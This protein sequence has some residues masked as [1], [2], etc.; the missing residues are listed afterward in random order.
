MRRS[1]WNNL[2]AEVRALI[3]GHTGQVTA[4]KPADAGEH[5]DITAT[6]WT[7]T[8]PVFI[9]GVQIEPARPEVWSL[10]REARISAHVQHLAPR[11]LWQVEAG[12]WLVLG[13]EHI[14][15][16]QPDYSPRSPD[17]EHLAKV[18]E[19]LHATPA[20]AYMTLRVERR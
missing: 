6:L 7:E 4:S 16:R 8:G 12:G 19:Q 3:E 9:K 15:G 18:V 1:D 17:L 10:R 11:L 14:D 2:P 13:L 5:S 20:P